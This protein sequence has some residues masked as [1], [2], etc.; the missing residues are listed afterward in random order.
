MQISIWAIRY[1][2]A[3]SWD[4]HVRVSEMYSCCLTLWE[5]EVYDQISWVMFLGRI[6]RLSWLRITFYIF[7]D[8][9][10][11]WKVNSDSYCLEANH[12]FYK[13]VCN[14]LCKDVFDFKWFSSID[15]CGSSQTLNLKFVVLRAPFLGVRAVRETTLKRKHRI[16]KSSVQWILIVS[17]TSLLQ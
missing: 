10:V 9:L 12:Y 14:D 2:L 5:R 8:F 6:T 16:L 17:I 1:L 4:V 13:Y 15:T 11:C 3:A 7:R